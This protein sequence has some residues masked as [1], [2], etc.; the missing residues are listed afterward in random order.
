MDAEVNYRSYPEADETVTGV[1]P[2]TR[3][4]GFN[5]MPR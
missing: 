2:A 3:D 4:Q 1:I 5:L